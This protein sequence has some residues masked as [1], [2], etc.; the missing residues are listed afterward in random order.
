MGRCSGIVNVHADVVLDC[1]PNVNT[2]EVHE[3]AATVAVD[4]E[5]TLETARKVLRQRLLT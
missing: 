1:S 4:A 3:T 5:A 2:S